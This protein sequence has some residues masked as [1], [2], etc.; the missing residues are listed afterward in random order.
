MG[1]TSS[2]RPSQ[3]DPPS[4]LATSNSLRHSEDDDDWS[5]LE[6]RDEEEEAD[7][8]DDAARPSGAG[9]SWWVASQAEVRNMKRIFPFS[10]PH[11][12]R[13]SM[14]REQLYSS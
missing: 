5:S 14:V 7:D 4:S 12:V 1:G 2:P 3:T 10:R 6:R 11:S 8:D 9:C 13:C